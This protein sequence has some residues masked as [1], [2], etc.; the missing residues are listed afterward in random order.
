MRT[1]PGLGAEVLL[2][3]LCLR[4]RLP[5]LCVQGLAAL[6]VFGRPGSI[7]SFSQPRPD[8]GES[9][10]S[11]R[12]HLSGLSLEEASQGLCGAERAG[13]GPALGRVFRG[14]AVCRGVCWLSLSSHTDLWGPLWSLNV[15]LFNRTPYFWLLGLSYPNGGGD[16]RRQS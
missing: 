2:Q 6:M 10:C 14:A 4:C 8:A 11:R 3:P 13:V 12:P 15:S 1:E 5:S 9:I 7:V 16:E